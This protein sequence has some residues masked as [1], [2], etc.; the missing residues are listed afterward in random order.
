MLLR[1]LLSFFYTCKTF[2]YC[3][4]ISKAHY[5]FNCVVNIIKTLRGLD[6]TYRRSPWPAATELDVRSGARPRSHGWW[7]R[8]DEER[9][10][11]A[12]ERAVGLVARWRGSTTQESGRAGA[13]EGGVAGTWVLTAVKYPFYGHK[14]RHFTMRTMHPQ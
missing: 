4:I 12:G 8:A 13:H 9:L 10:D 5:L 11:G 7:W 3:T 6:C 2:L 1:G 14:F